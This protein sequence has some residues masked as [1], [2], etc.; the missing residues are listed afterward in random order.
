MRVVVESEADTSVSEKED[1]L[2]AL[3]ED[4]QSFVKTSWTQ[5][6]ER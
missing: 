5:Q 2:V 4:C 3:F 1:M 6:T